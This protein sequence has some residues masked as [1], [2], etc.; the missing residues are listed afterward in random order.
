MAFRGTADASAVP[1]Y[2]PPAGGGAHFDPVG[3]AVRT[4]VAAGGPVSRRAPSRSPRPRT[5]SGPPWCVRGRSARTPGR[6]RGAC[7]RW[8]RTLRPPDPPSPG[9]PRPGRGRLLAECRRR[10]GHPRAA[11][12]VVSGRGP[13]A[14][15]SLATLACGA[16]RAGAEV[17]RAPP[18][19]FRPRV[20]GGRT[21]RP[22]RGT[23]RRPHPGS[24]RRPCG[25]R[26]RPRCGSGR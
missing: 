26:R 24:R 25:R 21:R 5:A 9:P 22:G 3:G 6:S 10:H 16:H 15:A 14:L 1:V 12:V 4:A 7:G 2:A 17:R 18:D 8:G 13:S 20:R 23:R 11:V 19:G